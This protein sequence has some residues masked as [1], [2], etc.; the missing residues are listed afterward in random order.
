MICF[1]FYSRFDYLSIDYWYLKFDL[2][3]EFLFS[4]RE[5]WSFPIKI[6]RK[7]IFTAKMWDLI[8]RKSENV[9]LYRA[10]SLGTPNNSRDILCKFWEFVVNVKWICKYK[11]VDAS[12]SN[13]TIFQLFTKKTDSYV[14]AGIRF[15]VGQMDNLFAAEILFSGHRQF[16]CP[17]GW[18]QHLCRS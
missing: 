10:F 1:K 15:L 9:L 3:F 5:I 16:H 2:K 4:V 18:I 14:I 11:L 12:P 13:V 17:C 8:F 7:K 6:Q